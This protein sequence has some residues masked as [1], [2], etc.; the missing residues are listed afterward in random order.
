MLKLVVSADGTRIAFDRI[1]SG[2]SLLLVHGT[3]TIRAQWAPIFAT[4]F[5]VAA[6]DRRG[7]GDSGDASE[8]AIASAI[9]LRTS[10]ALSTI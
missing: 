4:Q 9:S 1:G 8:Y 3:G 6:M 5:T 7:H 10:S 2:P